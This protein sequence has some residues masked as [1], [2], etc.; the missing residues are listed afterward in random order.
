MRSFLDGDPEPSD[1]DLQP[2][3]TRFK[4]RA[5]LIRIWQTERKTILF[6]T[7]DIDEALQHADRVLVMSRRP[8]TVREV[9]DVGLPRPRELDAPAYLERRDHIFMT[10]STSPHGDSHADQASAAD[11]RSAASP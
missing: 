9:V 5:D 6:V 8:A 2:Y 1:R 11:A 10:M 4:I 7:H 3:F